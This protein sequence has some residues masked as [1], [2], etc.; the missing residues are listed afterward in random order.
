[1]MTLKIQPWLMHWPSLRN[2]IRKRTSACLSWK[3]SFLYGSFHNFWNSS[4]L[5]HRKELLLIIFVFDINCELTAG[6][7]YV[8][9]SSPSGIAPGGCFPRARPQ[10]PCPGKGYVDVVRKERFYSAFLKYLRLRLLVS[11]SSMR[12]RRK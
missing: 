2:N 4:S 6:H 7:K 3:S 8:H 5:T 11:L 10:P 1:M 9:F 12:P